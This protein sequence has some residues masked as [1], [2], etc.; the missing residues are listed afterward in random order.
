[1]HLPITNAM[2]ADKRTVDWLRKA[3][4]PDIARHAKHL[5]PAAIRTTFE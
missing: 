3:K 1:M 4:H 2:T 5:F